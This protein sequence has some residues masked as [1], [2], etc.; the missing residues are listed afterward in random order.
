LGLLSFAVLG[1][2]T[3]PAHTLR[4]IVDG[5]KTP[6]QI[7]DDLAYRHFILAIAEHQNPSK[8]E[9]QR[10]EARL[11]PIGFSKQERDTCVFALAGVREELDAIDAARNQIAPTFASSDAGV[12]A[13]LATLK[14]QEDSIIAN[15][16]SRLR[17]SLGDGQAR[18]DIYVRNRVKRQIVI[19][20][21]AP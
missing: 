7:S 3:P 17:L 11:R 15:A 8:E 19:L 5:S 21:L 10:R 4:V 12:Q 14:S 6:D 16:R 20:G 18:L 13:R 1:A 2:Q 9:F